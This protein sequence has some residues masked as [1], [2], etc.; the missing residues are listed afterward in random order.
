MSNLWLLFEHIVWQSMLVGEWEIGAFDGSLKSRGMSIRYTVLTCERE[1]LLV[2]RE[3]DEDDISDYIDTLGL[4]PR[5]MRPQ[6]GTVLVRVCKKVPVN[7]STQSVNA[8]ALNATDDRRCYLKEVT[9]TPPGREDANVTSG[10]GIPEDILEE[11]EIDGQVTEAL[12]GTGG[13]RAVRRR[14]QAEDNRTHS[15]EEGREEGVE[16]QK[17]T[18][19]NGTN[20]TFTAEKNRTKEE[21]EEGNEMSLS[22]P[23]ARNKVA[24]TVEPVTSEEMVQNYISS[25]AEKLKPHQEQSRNLTGNKLS[26]EYDDYNQEVLCQMCVFL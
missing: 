21:L 4:G 22:G 11:L 15:G 12:N 14:R 20:T 17:Q 19:G 8:S 1:D 10:E 3:I 16:I 23:P 24:S 25:E 5:G 9:F 6:S 26:V 2:D 18:V 13:E 7:N